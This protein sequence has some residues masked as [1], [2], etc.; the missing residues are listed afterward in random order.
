MVVQKSTL[1]ETGHRYLCHECDK[2]FILGSK[3]WKEKSPERNAE[4]RKSARIENRGDFHPWKSWKHND[5]V[6]TVSGDG[7]ATSVG[8]GAIANC[9]L[10]LRLAF[11][12]ST[13][14]HQIRLVNIN[15]ATIRYNGTRMMFK[16]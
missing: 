14:N 16:T 2:R 11:F 4:T 1:M 5:C 15:I 3:E 8:H 12:S 7:A 13:W 10:R 6:A 9:Q